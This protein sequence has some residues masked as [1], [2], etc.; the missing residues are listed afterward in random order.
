MLRA[1]F[2]SADITPGP[3]CGLM[4]YEFRQQMLPPGNAGVHDPLFARALV[5]DAG[6]GPAALI[7]LDLA[8]LTN[9]VARRLRADVADTLGANAD[10]VILACSHTHSGPFPQLPAERARPEQVAYTETLSAA[11]RDAVARAAGLLYPVTL[12]VQEAAFALG[13]N[14]RV[15][16][17]EGIK[18]CWGPQEFPD[19]TPGAMTDPACVVLALRRVGGPGE[20][21]LWSSGVHGVVLGK[22]SRVV[23]ADW[24]GATCAMLDDLL[25]GRRSLFL[26]GAAGDTHP[27]IATQEDPA[28]LA[29][30]ARAASSFVDLLAQSTIPAPG[31]DALRIATRTVDFGGGELDLSVWRLGPAWIIAAP[32]ELFGALGHALRARLDAPMLLATVANGWTG[33]WPTAA[34]FDEGGYEINASWECR[35]GDG[36]RL[37]DALAAMAADLR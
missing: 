36:E 30:M 2:A 18:H 4:G 37:V 1:G 7:G 13:Y 5:L 23:S 6:D 17:P 27:W 29:T 19:R 11:L 15:P 8:V 14:R 16:T 32:V 22:T 35:R 10:R 34:A 26:A 12:G 33:Y 20:L 25:P 21:L 9:D 31:S 28:R 3:D 24:P